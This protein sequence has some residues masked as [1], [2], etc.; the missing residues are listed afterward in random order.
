MNFKKPVVLVLVSLIV[1]PSLLSCLVAGQSDAKSE[2]AL[3]KEALS[4]CYDAVKAVE[5]KGGNVTG[6]VAI[7]N[8]AARL[9]TQAELAYLAENYSSAVTLARQSKTQLSGFDAKASLVKNDA[10]NNGNLGFYTDAL[11]VIAGFIIFCVGIAVWFV[12]GRFKQRRV[13]GE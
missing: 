13:S 12:L 4:D 8:N 7:L 6:L 1:Y 5:A 3:A 2:I 9:L 10:L 11:L